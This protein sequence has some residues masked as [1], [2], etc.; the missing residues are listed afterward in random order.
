VDG[1]GLDIDAML[2]L[3]PTA[4]QQMSDKRPGRALVGG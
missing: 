3:L 2:D 4:R 1:I